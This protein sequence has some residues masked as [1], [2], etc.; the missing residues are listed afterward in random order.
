MISCT[1]EDGNQASLRHT[2]VDVLVIK[3]NAI[4]MVKRTAK[5]L[6]GGKWGVVG[7]YVER[8]ETTAQAVAREVMEETGW[9]LKNLQLL[10]IRDNPDR[11]HEDRQNIS[12]VYLA[13]AVGQT[14]Q[15]DWESDEVKWFP[16]D[17]LPPREQIAFDHAA[18]IDLY[19]RYLK[20][21]FTLPVL[22]QP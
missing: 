13:E 17:N 19:A 15:P 1:F 10:T 12:F 5:L 8:D 3:D 2:V 7:G 14:G 4:L 9:Q 6:E 18:S 21:N 22:P 20:E 16:L 11:P